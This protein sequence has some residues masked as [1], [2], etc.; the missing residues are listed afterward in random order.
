MV[1]KDGIEEEGW[2]R[3][4]VWIGKDVKESEKKD[5]DLLKDEEV[6]ESK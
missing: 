5:Q 6:N 3:R 2:L 4:M 1:L